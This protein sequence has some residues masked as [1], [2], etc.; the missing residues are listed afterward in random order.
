MNGALLVCKKEFLE[1]SKDRRTV[2]FTFLLPLVLYPL[3]FAMVGGLSRTDEAN[4]QGR[5]SRVVLVDPGGVLT[6]ALKAEP[7]SFELVAPP[8]GDLRQA[9][10][11]QRLEMKI[12]VEADAPLKLSRHRTFTVTA[13]CDPSEEASGLALTRLRKILEK[14]NRRWVEERLRLAGVSPELDRPSRLETQEMGDLGLKVGRTLGAFLPYLLMLMM[15]A[16]SMQHG[17]YATAGE[18]ERGTLLS[19]L[20][21]RLPRHQ[22]IW[23]KLLY[24]FAVGLLSAFINLLSMGVSIGSVV[25][26]GAEGQAMSAGSLAD[27]ARPSTLGLTFLLMAPLGLLFANFIVMMGIRARNSVEAGTSIMPGM[28]VVLVMAVFSMA[29]GLEKLAFLPYVPILNV[30]LAI[31]KLFSQQGNA[32]EFWVALLMTLGLAA[33]MTWLSTRLLNRETSVFTV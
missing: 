20:S 19:L 10:R 29:P 25:R 3:L 28:V 4:R 14:Q 31:R 23:G 27:L 7:E 22:I 15:F 2:F 17:I 24:V 33:V 6:S 1:L 32:F 18:K 12:Q 16:G 26:A 30:S 9:I 21:T 8:A 5:A 11:D 13:A